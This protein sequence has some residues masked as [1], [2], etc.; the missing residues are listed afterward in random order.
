MLGDYAIQQTSQI[1]QR[2]CVK[3][4]PE[5]Q[6]AKPWQADSLASWLL[7]ASAS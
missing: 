4:I 7:E 2:L 5:L 3:G 1:V 6:L